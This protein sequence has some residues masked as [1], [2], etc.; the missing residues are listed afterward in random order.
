MRGDA[1]TNSSLSSRHF[2]KRHLKSAHRE[3]LSDNIALCKQ[4]FD[5]WNWPA[6]Y[7]RPKALRFERWQ[8]K[9]FGNRWYHKRCGSLVQISER[10]RL[11]SPKDLNTIDARQRRLA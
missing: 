8:A 10:L 5:S 3:I 2:V 9:T 6:H 7:R 1:R 4:L 11:N